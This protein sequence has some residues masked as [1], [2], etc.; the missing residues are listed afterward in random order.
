MSALRT[1]LVGFG[2]I[3]RGLATDTRMAAYFPIATHA[4]ALKADSNFNWVGVVDPDLKARHAAEADWKV[5]GFTTLAEASILAPDVLVLATPPGGRADALAALPSVKAV[6]AEKP[7]GNVDGEALIAAAETRGIPLQVNYWRRGDETLGALGAGELAHRIGTLQ[8]GTG[9]YGNGLNNNGSH[10][11]DMIR[12]LIGEPAW[13]QAI[14]DT[15]EH[16]GGPVADDMHIAFAL[17][18]TGGAVISVHAVDFKHYR[19][20]A[21]DLWGTA[22]RLALQQETLDIRHLPHAPNRGLDDEHEIAADQG[23][24]LA[25]TVADALPRLYRNLYDATTTGCALLS[26]GTSARATERIIDLI[27]RSADQGNARLAVSD[28]A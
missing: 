21:L 15:T 9:V 4:Q 10:L 5:P 1:L 11:I 18:F 2:G 12:M 13:V 7:L 14:S 20:V 8:A 27:R 24:V 19:E 17:G 26:P 16:T 28:S 23:Q 25:C 6:F 3:A 22:G